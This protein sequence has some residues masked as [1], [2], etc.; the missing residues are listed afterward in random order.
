MSKRKTE[1]FEA[2]ERLARLGVKRFGKWTS[3]GSN[4]MSWKWDCEHV[5]VHYCERDSFGLD[6]LMLY[7][8]GLLIYRLDNCE[9]EVELLRRYLLLDELADV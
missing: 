6:T 8:R 4:G 5:H 3:S 9:E 7:R 2:L 1:S